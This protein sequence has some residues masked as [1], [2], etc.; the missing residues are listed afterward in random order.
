M[1]LQLFGLE[2]SLSG[3]EIGIKFACFR[4]LES[5]K[6]SKFSMQKCAGV[7]FWLNSGFPDMT[8]KISL[9]K[10]H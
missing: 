9:Q 4:Q 1:G 2:G 10:Y 5:M 6:I 7:K 3:F 8:D